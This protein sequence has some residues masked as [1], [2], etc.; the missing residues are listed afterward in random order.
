M[1]KR[2]TPRIVEI[3]NAHIVARQ[4]GD[5][6]NPDVT[7]HADTIKALLAGK[8]IEVVI[9]MIEKRYC[10]TRAMNSLHEDNKVID[11]Y[12]RSI[13]KGFKYVLSNHV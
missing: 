4:S 3:A 5:F 1:R 8:T 12:R 13:Y 11:S 7:T 2:T 6:N 9:R 10:S